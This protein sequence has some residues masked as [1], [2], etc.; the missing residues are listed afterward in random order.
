[1]NFILRLRWILLTAG[2][3]LLSR[4]PLFAQAKLDKKISVVIHHRSLTWSLEE[5]GRKGGFY[6]SYNTNI[7]NGDSVVDVDGKGRT[8]R[9]LLEKL[10]G[11][12]YEYLESGRYIILLKKTSGPPGKIYTVTGNV[13]DKETG[14]KLREVSIYESDQL[15]SALTDTNGFFRLRLR[16][17]SSKATLIISKQLYRDTLLFIQPGHD[18]EFEC[19]IT[20]EHIAELMPFTI[21]NHVEKTWMGKLLL[22]SK[23]VIQ[24][25]NLMHFF[26]DKPIQFSLTPGLGT[27][28]QMGAQVINKFSLNALGGYTAGVNGLEV[29]GLFNIDKKEVKYVQVA[30]IFNIVG[31]Q[32]RGLQVAGIYNQ[33]LDSV[34]G[35]QAGGISNKVTGNFSGL[36]VGG[37]IN[38]VHGDMK[39]VQAA[40]LANITRGEMK[41]LQVGGI[42]NR[43]KNLKGVQ[44]GLINSA[45]TSSGYMIGLINIVKNGLHE[46]SLSSNEILPFCLSY[47]T[48]TRKIYS[49]LLAG[50]AP[51]GNEKAYAL[52][53]GFGRE[54][55]LS[56]VLAFSAEFTFQHFYLGN[57]ENVPVVYR[58][59]PALQVRLGRKLSLFGGPA[60][61][62]Y[63]PDKLSA[64]PGY[65][66]GLPG[67]GTHTFSIGKNGSAWLGWSLGINFF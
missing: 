29:A 51:F 16:E 34:Q 39:G 11:G 63:S 55:P 48:G 61:S 14:E 31:G 43:A 10:L 17:K 56:P 3:G 53:F 1:M 57:W 62:M 5:I 32:V 24:S 41:G 37:L 19:S 36:Q 67:G 27:H 52:G 18:Q 66:S 47:K 40:G 50:A 38:E 12:N 58:L 15:V 28:G 64:A 46:I 60:L 6:F 59:Q 30:G 42:V 20:Q 65:K 54:W 21:T 2:I 44:I 25:M 33:D 49:I 4:T 8:I 45:D 23:E 13:R 26:A 9:Q 7:L 22:S 35:V